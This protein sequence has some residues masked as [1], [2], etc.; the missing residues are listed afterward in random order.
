MVSLVIIGGPT[1]SGK[2]ALALDLAER[3]GG[4]IVNADSMQQYRDLRILTA[5]PTLAELR[6]A[7][8]YLYGHLPA[9][10][11]GSVGQWLR[12][13]TRVID[14]IRNQE[15]V[16]IVVGGTGLYLCALLKGI[17]AVPDVPSEIRLATSERFDALGVPGFHEE[18]AKRDPEQAAL[19]EPGDRQRLIRAAEVLEATGKSLI[20]WRS[21]P[22]KRLLLPEPIVGVALMPPRAELHG[23]IEQ[24]LQTMIDAGALDELAALRA[25]NLS[26][27]LPL[28]KAVAVPE[29][30]AHLDGRLDLITAVERAAAKTRQYAKRQLTW[31]RHQLPELEPMEKFGDSPEAVIE[32]S[33]AVPLDLLTDPA[34]RHT[35]RSTR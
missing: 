24:R 14:E 15:R 17:A 20:Y 33:V 19:L 28:M 2:S 22:R 26:P 13:A 16:P 34:I 1:G 12:Q 25:K 3:I 21:Q 31:L 23:R 11:P 10:K 7:P 29:L 8:H 35:V 5:R 4:A 18:L 32:P 9:E 27:D 6:R 30:L